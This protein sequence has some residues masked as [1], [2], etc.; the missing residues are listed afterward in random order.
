MNPRYASAPALSIVRADRPRPHQRAF[1][2]GSP[3]GNV[4][5][6]APIAATIYWTPATAKWEAPGGWDSLGAR[7]SAVSAVSAGLLRIMPANWHTVS[8]AGGGNSSR[9]MHTCSRSISD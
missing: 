2:R 4:N 8:I 3:A 5:L 6:G 1:L 9:N 7:G